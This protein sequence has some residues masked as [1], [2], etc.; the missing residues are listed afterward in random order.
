[1]QIII[2]ILIVA[3]AALVTYFYVE[4]QSHIEEVKKKITDENKNILRNIDIYYS[5][6][7]DINIKFDT[8]ANHIKGFETILAKYSSNDDKLNTIMKDNSNNLDSL[9]YIAGT[10]NVV[11][12]HTKTIDEGIVKVQDMLNEAKNSS[13]RSNRYNRNSDGKFSGKQPETGK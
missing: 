1:M 8:I 9:K 13:K 12:E 10:I 11:K 5:M 6:I 2:T 3:L 4:I 7:R